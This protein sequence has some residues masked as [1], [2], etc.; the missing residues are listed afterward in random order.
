ML[1]RYMS[2]EG[3]KARR[4][5]EAPSSV[6]TAASVHSSVHQHQRSSGVPLA[7]F[8]PMPHASNCPPSVVA[9]SV[10]LAVL[11]R[12]RV[13]ECL[14]EAC[15]PGRR[16]GGRGQGRTTP[17]GSQVRA[18]QV[19]RYSSTLE[20]ADHV[21]N[22]NHQHS[23]LPLTCASLQTCLFELVLLDPLSHVQE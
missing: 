21:A 12:R 23:A 2:V 17:A 7:A 9:Q 1:Y 15:T 8:R 19:G 4:K 20:R 6:S 10:F 16:A 14:T 18:R 3:E 11:A 22:A 13:P 5:E